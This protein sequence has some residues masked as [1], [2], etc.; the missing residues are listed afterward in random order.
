[1]VPYSFSRLTIRNGLSS[2]QVNSFYKDPQGFLWIGTM[3]GLNRYDG[4]QFRV[5]TH[6]SRDTN[7]IS[8]DYISRILEGPE[9]KLWIDTRN[10][11]N[12]FDPL[13]EKFS[14]NP[15]AHF[16]RGGMNITTLTDLKKDRR[17]NYWFLGDRQLLYRQNAAGGPATLIHR[18]LYQQDEMAAFDF[19]SKG[20][21]QVLHRNGT[22]TIINAET[23]R[24][25]QSYR[26]PGQIFN[27]VQASFLFFID[28][29]DQLWI[30]GSG[31]S[32][33]SVLWY[34]PVTTAA[35]YLDR[36]NATYRLNSNLVISIQQDDNGNM[37]FAT[38]HGGVN[39][40][41]KKTGVVQY[42]LH[43]DDQSTSLSQNSINTAFKDDK[44]I[45]W[46]GTYKQGISFYHENIVKFPLM[47]RR[48]SDPQSL[49]FDDVNKFVED[50][51]GNVWIGTNGGGLIYFN[52]KTNR[53]QQFW[54]EPDNDNSISNNVIVSLF[55][56]RDDKL[57]IG[58]YYGGLDCYSNGKFTHFRH[59]PANPYSISD[60]RVWEIYEDRKGE[61]WVGTMYGLNRF[62]RASH[63]FNR[64]S[65][66]RPNS[67][68]S[69]YICAFA[70]DASGSLW[71][72]TD[73]GID[74]ID[75][76]QRVTHYGAASS[77]L[78]NNNILSLL[79]DSR[80]LI[81]AGTRDGLNVFDQAT[82]KF[83]SF[84]MRDG[85]PGNTVLN[86]LE[87]RQHR[88]WISTNNGLAVLQVNNN[89]Q[90][91]SFRA[92][93]YDQSDGL[94]G[95]EFN[96]NAAL[97]LS[98]GE[99]IFG[100]A[101]GFNIFDPATI[102]PGGLA[103]PVVLTQLQLFNKPV[104]IGEQIGNRVLL[105]Q[106]ISH[107]NRI[108]LKH[109]EN[110][111]SLEFASLNYSNPEK[112]RY[113]YLLE[114][115]NKEWVYTTGAMRRAVYTNL[116]PGTYVFRVR[117]ANEEG[118]WG[119]ARALLTIHIRSPF[120]KTPL[121]FMLYVLVA[122]L[123]LVFARKLLLDRAH[124]RFE[125]AQQRKE[126][127]RI[128]Q[129][130]ALKTKFFTNVSHEF[131]TPLSLILSPLDKIIRK[132]GDADQKKQL[133]LV[134][135][136]AKRL[137]NLVNQLLDFR[138]MEVQQFRLHPTREDIISFIQDITTSFSD[139]SEKRNILLEFRANVASLS[140]MFDRDKLEKI[141]FNLLS[142][143]FK[144]TPGGG[145]VTVEV[146]YSAGENAE[147]ELHVRDTG[148]GIQPDMK[149][150]IFERFYQLDVPG[151]IQGTGSGIGL[152]I[153]KE[154]VKLHGGRIEV[155]SEPEKGTDFI[156]FLPVHDEV[157]EPGMKDEVLLQ[158]L[159]PVH[160]N[161][162]Q[163]DVDKSTI[164]L[165]ED[166][167]DFRFYLKDNLK[168][169]Y[170]VI[171]A[172]N[173]KLGW[174]KAKE[175]QPDLVVSDIMMPLMNG[176]ELSRKIKS[177]PRTSH[178]PVVLLTAM[179]NDETELEG[180]R[181]GINDYISKPFT[182]EILA[183]RIRNLL[184]LREQIRKRFVEQVDI[185][186]ADVAATPVDEIFIKEAFDAVERNM[187]N[188]DFS[189]E[190]LSRDLH[191]SRVALYKKILSVTGKTPI[192]FIR[193]MRLKRAAQ[194]LQGDSRTIAEIAYAVGYNN[195]KIFSR[196]FKEEFGQTPTQYQSGS[197]GSSNS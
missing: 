73:N 89:K 8:D 63:R 124:M 87:D 131:R 26:L 181:A 148:I 158:P 164:L 185:R 100:G 45:I 62:D 94:Q 22:V 36:E 66:Y 184:A 98:T 186:P 20:H 175:H 166:N 156:V 149:E 69:D 109:N 145:N 9:N 81:W 129:L 162:E 190:D 88:L 194:M 21:C 111:L 152:V 157:P 128:Q 106:S 120:W 123:I 39:I 79:V 49:P 71:I 86:I 112:V 196:Y 14:R 113:A 30:T 44:G 46:L 6:D 193:I 1:M 147:L 140:M 68:A 121:A 18:S 127:E 58:S 104:G 144:Y 115:F 134:Q 35:R 29:Q 178:I 99:L 82:G 17:G 93:S 161:G 173:G 195:P 187:D 117:A 72:G 138:K 160:L 197:N 97:R 101:N 77:G 159:A 92:I 133:Q 74:L 38:D 65:S 5:F 130:D 179:T 34:D 83:R 183:S 154:F 188:P 192:E 107:T 76:L 116:D 32:P 91:V 95:T 19:D 191:M 13:T 70:E 143:A 54:H 136:N 57:W 125:V 78:S 96:E 27:G 10:G 59:D 60:N 176:I 119:E 53:F 180:F 108:D 37:W 16:Q 182:F 85:L 170:N 84:H 24:I 28:R 168:Q 12:I 11:L 169:F 51:N 55:I 142:N 61:L 171:E 102:R 177:D 165:V 80:G 172:M 150:K 141:L 56:D 174:E 153:T 118:V 105:A 122:G 23:G 114:G 64:V 90:G 48:L 146:L 137:L 50:K 47:R 7:T 15:A 135:R 52:R 103:A 126:A 40:F 2:N 75:T 31:G 43:D 33:T 151:S 25:I 4:Y 167:E 3:S 189:V 110:M 42:I 41:N 139:I 67:I 163:E 155:E 132:S